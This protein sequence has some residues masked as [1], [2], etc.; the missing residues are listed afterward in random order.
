[1][2]QREANFDNKDPVEFSVEIQVTDSVN[3]LA[4]MKFNCIEPLQ[5]QLTAERLNRIRDGAA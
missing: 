3:H 2:S 4:R 1:M 5:L